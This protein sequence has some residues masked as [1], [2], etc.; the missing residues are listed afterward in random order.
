MRKR[1][2][3]ASCYLLWLSGMVISHH[4]V[5]HVPVPASLERLV[6]K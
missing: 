2:I 5:E 4:I 1:T 6:T 3:L